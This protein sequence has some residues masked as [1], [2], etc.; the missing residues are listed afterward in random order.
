MYSWMHAS[1]PL[2]LKLHLSYFSWCFWLQLRSVH[3]SE[4]SRIDVH[5]HDA[6]IASF[7]NGSSVFHALLLNFTI[8]ET[9]K[10]YDGRFDVNDVSTTRMRRAFKT[11]GSSSTI[12]QPRQQ[13]PAAFGSCHI[14][15]VEVRTAV[16][17][18]W[19]HGAGE[20]NTLT[21][22]LFAHRPLPTYI[23]IYIQ[24]VHRYTKK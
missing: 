2:T 17:I 23:Y 1:R 4:R 3:L 15:H 8:N 11:L 19:L 18:Y 16:P 5:V 6:A 12:C 9:N 22:S 13:Q 10:A 14:P 21:P 20:S 24:C 7:K